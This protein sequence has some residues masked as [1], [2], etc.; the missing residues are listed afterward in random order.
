ML[1]NEKK[2]GH[3]FERARRDVWED[4]EE[5]KEGRNVYMERPM[6]PAIHMT[7]LT[8]VGGEAIGPVE[9]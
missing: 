9:A 7:Y 1:V 6:D 2:E 4:M 3:D 5:D 8:S